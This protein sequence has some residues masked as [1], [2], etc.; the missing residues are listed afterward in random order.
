MTLPTK[1]NLG[2]LRSNLRDGLGQTVGASANTPLLNGILHRSQVFLFKRMSDKERTTQ[3]E[4]V[5]AQ[6]GQ[7]KYDWPDTIDPK[8]TMEIWVEDTSDTDFNMY[9]MIEGI[10]RRH[11]GQQSTVEQD[12]PRRYE[13][14]AQLE[15]WPLPDSNTY[16][17][18]IEGQL[19]LGAFSVDTDLATL[20]QDLILQLALANAKAHYRQPDANAIA[21]QF[22]LELKAENADNLGHQRFVRPNGS[23]RKPG[24]IFE[25]R[26]FRHRNT[27]DI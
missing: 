8:K 23:S 27:L 24:N 2:Q 25:D 4:S 6:T 19:R 1:K 17:F 9:P 16:T 15:V 20:D 13:R 11:Y 7:E 5:I 10:E 22:T 14:R 12:R 21:D 26:S 3:D 18:H